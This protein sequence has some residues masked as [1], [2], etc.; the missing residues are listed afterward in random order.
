M[1]V[2]YWKKSM[3][4][5]E[6]SVSKNQLLVSLSP[7]SADSDFN[8]QKANIALLLI[9]KSR[10]ESEY[11]GKQNFDISGEIKEKYDQI[12]D[13]E[14]ALFLKRK[15]LFDEELLKSENNILMALSRFEASEAA[16]DAASEEF[17]V[18]SSLYEKG[19]EKQT[20]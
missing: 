1:R 4:K 5:E 9:K 11:A 6:E 12:F 10:L 16:F 3:S 19:L 2:G 8:I 7:L 20:V 17:S 15:A 14:Y 18:V 13:N